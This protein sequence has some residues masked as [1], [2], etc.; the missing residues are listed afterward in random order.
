MRAHAMADQF[1]SIDVLKKVFLKPFSEVCNMSK[2]AL[3]DTM[4]KVAG[5]GYGR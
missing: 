1:L 2:T 5:G 4:K 3:Y